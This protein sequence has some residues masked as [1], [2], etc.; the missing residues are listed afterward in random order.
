M[1]RI[2]N[3]ILYKEAICSKIGI[4]KEQSNYEYKRT[5]LSYTGYSYGSISS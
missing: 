4:Q 5:N 3:N 2:N 1:L